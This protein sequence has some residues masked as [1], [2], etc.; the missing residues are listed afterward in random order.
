[1]DKTVSLIQKQFPQVH[2]QRDVSLSGYTTLKVGGPADYFMTV[3]GEK[4]FCGALRILQEQGM[5]HLV[6]GNGSNLLV[7][8]GGFRGVVLHMGKGFSA[9]Y[10]TD[11]GLYAQAG[12]LMS[13][14]SRTALEHQLTG[15]EFAQGIP[16]TVGGGVYMNAGAYGG[17]MCQVM[18][19]VRLFDG[20]E[21][22]D[23]PGQDMCFGYRHSLAMEKGYQVLGAAFALQQGDKAE[24]EAKMKDFAARRREKQPLEYPSAGSFFKRP[25]GYFAGALIE[26]SGLK[27]LTV[28]GAQVSEK[29]AGF[30]INIGGATAGDFLELME[31][32]QQE[33][34]C[35]FGVHLENEV[36]IVGSEK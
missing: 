9:I 10:P 19:F 11:Q 17:E 33:V 23:V 28:G 18:Q 8:D 6:L 13:V 24:I 20:K 14:L 35:R 31:K 7:R 26:Q 5:P 1:M 12:A 15:L 34:Y 21:I 32:V 2:I 4:E 27:G 29:H 25:Q 30:L 22:R 36:R 16:G 3:E